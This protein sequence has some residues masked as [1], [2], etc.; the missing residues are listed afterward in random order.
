MSEIFDLSRKRRPVT[1]TVYVTQYWN[2]A[3]ETFV[4]DVSDSERSRASVA[5]AMARA[6]AAWFTPQNAHALL[7]GMVD[8]M[9]DRPEGEPPPDHMGA[10]DDAARALESSLYPDGE[11]WASKA[12]WSEK[13]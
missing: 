13:P 5:D 9:M 11:S 4:A 1:Y 8:R 7:L 2:G 10:V 6:F 3:V 12:A